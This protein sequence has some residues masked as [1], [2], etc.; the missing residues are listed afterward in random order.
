M[1]VGNGIN[2]LLTFNLINSNICLAKLYLKLSDKNKI[3]VWKAPKMF[4]FLIKKIF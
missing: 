4:L 1:S 3:E 2:D